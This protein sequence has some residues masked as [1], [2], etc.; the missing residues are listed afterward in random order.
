MFV[1]N[2]I[3][4]VYIYGTHSHQIERFGVGYLW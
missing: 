2:R 3:Y 4:K 1:G